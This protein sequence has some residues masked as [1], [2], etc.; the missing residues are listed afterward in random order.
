MF[1]FK[2]KYI[3]DNMSRDKKMLIFLFGASVLALLYIVLGL[4]AVF[5]RSHWR[6]IGGMVVSVGIWIYT[7]IKTQRVKEEVAL[8]ERIELDILEEKTR[9][10]EILRKWKV[11]QGSYYLMTQ[12]EILEDEEIPVAVIDE[13]V[14]DI[15]ENQIHEEMHSDEEVN[16]LTAMLYGSP[17]ETVAITGLSETKNIEIEKNHNL[18]LDDVPDDEDKCIGGYMTT[19]DLSGKTVSVAQG[20]YSTS[21]RNNS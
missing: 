13:R 14:N 19:S 20:Y 8:E 5:S 16:R 21:D 10:N 11:G 2:I 4:I 9:G 3:K 6:W 15:C 18:L 12:E 7:W 1:D 17:E